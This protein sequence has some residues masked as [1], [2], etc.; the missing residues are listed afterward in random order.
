MIKTNTLI[1]LDGFGYSEQKYGNAIA[2]EGIPNFLRLWNE[3]PHTLISASGRRVGLPDGQ[4][5]NS[6]VGH[7][8]IGSGRVVYQDITRID[9]SIEDGEFFENEQL[10]KAVD[11]ALKHNGR[12]H[13]CGLLGDGGVHSSINHLFALLRL[14]KKRGAKT[15][16]QKATK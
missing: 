16:W 1:I 9:K 3:F 5:G 15:K 2:E 12:V 7:L 10:N 13:L 6:E 11:F 8:N 4:M 14:C